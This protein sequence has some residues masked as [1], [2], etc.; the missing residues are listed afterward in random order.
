[1]AH[2]HIML[3]GVPIVTHAGAP[4]QSVAPIGGSA[5]LRMSGGAGIK[6]QHWATASGSVSGN[7]MMPPGL[8]GLN[9]SVPLELRLTEVENMVG[10]GPEF[11]LTSTPREDKAP[12]A[13][14]QLEDQLWH[15]CACS[16]ADG[17]VTVPPVAGAIRY[18]V[19][20]MPVYSVFTDKPP[21]TQNT[22]HGW[23]FSWEEA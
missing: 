23:S 2:L 8:D 20:W 13:F 11:L 15:R 3:G 5:V 12:W 10:P 7:G 18:Q 6:Q 9:Y 17:V 22:S 16:F 14:Y 4:D 1:M 19:A 21:K